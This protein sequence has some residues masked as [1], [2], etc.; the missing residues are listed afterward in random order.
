M[1]QEG[2]LSYTRFGEFVRICAG[3]EGADSGKKLFNELVKL[4][5]DDA[6]LSAGKEIAADDTEFLGTIEALE[7]EKK[8]AEQAYQKRA[9]SAAAR[10][11]PK[12]SQA[13]RTGASQVRAT[14]KGVA[15][16][17]SAPLKLRALPLKRVLKK[18]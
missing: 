16:P 11:T 5:L 10:N 3:R 17:L 14:G 9:A 18:P 1:Q 2:N 6:L 7:K 8:A 13:S 4:S 12:V 15:L